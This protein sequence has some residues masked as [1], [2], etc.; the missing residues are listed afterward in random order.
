MT[1]V[2]L[3][4]LRTKALELSEPERA[5]LAHDLVAS[6]DGAPET[7]VADEWNAE[8]LRRLDQIDAGA[9]SF[10]SRDEFNRLMRQHLK[11]A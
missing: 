10:M 4:Q 11:P 5:E 8:I 3:E 9:A 7:G 6:L 1:S 2:A